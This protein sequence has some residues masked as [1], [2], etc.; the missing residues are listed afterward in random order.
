MTIEGCGLWV[1]ED[2]LTVLVRTRVGRV[3][4]VSFESE[5]LCIVT[6]MYRCWSKV[7]CW[8]EGRQ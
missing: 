1:M 2:V 8:G 7:D 6:L 3:G 4:R 5:C